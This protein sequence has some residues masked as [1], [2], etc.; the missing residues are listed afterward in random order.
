MLF[1]LS[2]KLSLVIFFLKGQTIYIY[3]IVS[4]K[5]FAAAA[6]LLPFQPQSSHKQH[7]NEWCGCVSLNL[8]YWTQKFEFYV[9]FLF[10]CAIKHNLSFDFSLNY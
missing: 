3:G 4:Q 7:K 9:V 10:L 2:Y 1:L 8:N 5:V 6:Q